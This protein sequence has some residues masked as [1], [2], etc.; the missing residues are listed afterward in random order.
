MVLRLLFL[1]FVLQLNLVKSQDKPKLFIGLVIDQMRQEYLIRYHDHFGEGGF[2][3]IIEDGFSFHNHHYN[4]VPTH[5]APGHASIYTGTTPA[6]HGIVA[7]TW[8]DK[9]KQASHYCVDDNNYKT[10]GDE[11]TAGNKSAAPLK[12]STVG[13]ELKVAS[14]GKSKVFAV[15]LKDRSAILP[16]GHAA[17]GAFW[18][19]STGKFVSSTYYM[20][21]LPKWLINFNDQEHP[22]ALLEKNWTLINNKAAYTNSTKDDHPGEGKLYHED[23]SFPHD[24]VK[25]SQNLENLGVIK[26][27]PQGNTLTRLIAESLIKNEELGKDEFCDFLSISFSSIDYIGHAFGPNSIEMEDAI[28]RLDRELEAFLTFLDLT[29]GEN[30]YSLFLTADHGALQVP[31]LLKEHQIPSGLFNH[32]L[33]SDLNQY[34]NK[35]LATDS[36]ILAVQN[37]QVFLN[38]EEI[39]S[40]KLDYKT[41]YSLISNYIYKLEGVYKILKKNDLLV[42]NYGTGLNA[43]VQKG[44]H[45]Q[46]SGDLWI[47]LEPGWISH[48]KTGTTHGS[49]F[50]YDTHVPLIWY[51]TGIKPGSSTDRVYITDIAPTSSFLIGSPQPNSTEGDILPIVKK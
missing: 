5:T 16:A 15:A 33:A 14:A 20:N 40:T 44:F 36:L 29:L 27:C 28:I 7:N 10:V 19:S 23:N 12:S 22:K 2:K 24:L 3:K 47:I 9:K 51:G 21:D 13:D 4:Y 17:D 31:T 6:V 30:Q 34:L 49:P 38:H 50:N 45:P 43:L 35:E 46:M 37:H 8:F 26:A 39:E 41:I 32:N 18:Y 42:E 1:T 48:E 11:T 25:S